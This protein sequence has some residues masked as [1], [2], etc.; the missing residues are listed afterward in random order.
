[1][2]AGAFS[3]EVVSSEQL[4]AEAEATYISNLKYASRECEQ[5]CV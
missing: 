5:V 2:L 3:R 1:M 4:W